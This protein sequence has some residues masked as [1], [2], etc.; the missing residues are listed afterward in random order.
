MSEATAKSSPTYKLKRIDFFGRRVPVA[1]QNENGPC[2]LLAIANILLLKKQIELPDSASDI[3]QNRLVSLI[4]GHL[5]DTNDEQKVGK[6]LPEEYKVNLRKNVADAISILPKL[7]TGVDVNVRFHDVKGFEFTDEIAIF[8]LLDISLV[9]GWLVDPQDTAAAVLAQKS[10]NELVEQL[11]T[12]LGDATPKRLLTPQLS[13]HTSGFSTPRRTTSSSLAAVAPSDLLSPA[14]IPSSSPALHSGPFSHHAQTPAKPTAATQSATSST[15]R[16]A[17]SFPTASTAAAEVPHPQGPAASTVGMSPAASASGSTADA[18]ADATPQEQHLSPTGTTSSS[19]ANQPSITEAQQTGGPTGSLVSVQQQAATTDVGTGEERH[20]QTG[21][22]QPSADQLQKVLASPAAGLA[23]RAYPLPVASSDGVHAST[24]SLS[25]P[26]TS[27]KFDAHIATAPTPYP[28]LASELSQPNSPVLAKVPP[29]SAPSSPNGK[30]QATASAS[31]ESKSRFAPSDADHTVTRA[32]A[33]AIIVGAEE[34]K[35]D[36]LADSLDKLSMQPEVGSTSAASVADLDDLS[37][38][39]LTQAAELSHAADQSDSAPDLKLDTAEDEQLQLALAISLEQ[40]E[41]EE[42]NDISAEAHQADPEAQSS[43]SH[44]AQAT[45][46]S[47]I[48]ETKASSQPSALGSSHPVQSSADARVEP[49]LPANDTSTSGQTADSKGQQTHKQQS[50]PLAQSE[51]TSTAA[52]TEADQADT[53]KQAAQP[54]HAASSSHR[55]LEEHQLDLLSAQ[56]AQGTDAAEGSGSG[57]HQQAPLGDDNGEAQ[58]QQSNAKTPL[59]SQ[60]P[61]TGP[62]RTAS[63]QEERSKAVAHAHIIQDFLDN[64]SSQ[65]TYHGLVSL[66]EGL[67]PNELAVFFRNNHFNTIFLHRGALHILVTDQGYEYEKHVV[68][69]KLDDLTGNT[70]FLKADFTPYGS[71]SLEEQ[72]SDA[73]DLVQA[74]FA[75]RG[76]SKPQTG[77]GAVDA[78]FALALQLQEEEERRASA[79]NQQAQQQQHQQQQQAGAGQSRQHRSSS[80]P[81]QRGSSHGR[82]PSGQSRGQASQSYANPLMQ[83]QGQRAQQ[84]QQQQQ[85]TSFGSAV[86]K[87]FGWGSKK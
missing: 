4:A 25:S 20:S 9:H 80:K 84:S 29:K 28:S 21:H 39:E 16:S 33:D 86:S 6:G 72:A 17:S 58:G 1:L 24:A 12:I 49:S 37:G 82:L 45:S 51:A 26:Q 7:T 55:Q 76:P 44:D 42:A 57:S 66:R 67:R 70:Q 71:T 68:W 53:D 43:H 74:A 11:V 73:A 69:E 13:R 65:L 78:D 18:A 31:A 32:D 64:S 10:Y 87:F 2:P 34:S 52:A 40:Q 22:A 3:S 59:A 54:S 23:D 81:Q 83:Q 50:Q 46:L 56:N 19:D 5:L 35:T 38:A 61:Q 85:Q 63:E 14:E 60:G 36:A 27:G 41:A 8:D 15:P 77:S 75:G 79:H 62:T 30:G 48:P 47:S